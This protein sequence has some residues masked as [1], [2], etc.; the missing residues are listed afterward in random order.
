MRNFYAEHESFILGTGFIIFLLA[1]WE[2]VPLWTTLPRGMS[3][4][5]TTPSK[6]AAAFYELLLNGEIEKHFYVSA[7]AFLAGLG[8]SII[9]GLPRITATTRSFRLME[10]ACHPSYPLNSENARPPGT[11]TVYLSCAET[12][13]VLERMKP[14]ARRWIYQ[15]KVSMSAD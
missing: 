12:A 7:I 5:F 4:F 15:T 8:L 3:L 14:E 10:M 9:V 1:V 13:R 2:S 6:I 11:F